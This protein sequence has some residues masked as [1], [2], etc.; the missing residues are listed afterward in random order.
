[1]LVVEDEKLTFYSLFSFMENTEDEEEND[2]TLSKIKENLENYSTRKIKTLSN[3][4]IDSM[5]EMNDEKNALE[6]KVESQ[7]VK[8]LN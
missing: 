5:C 6:E 4:L 1:M 7:E 2:I 8:S 3:L